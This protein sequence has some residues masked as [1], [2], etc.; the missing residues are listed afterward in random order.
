MSS[1]RAKETE[2][3]LLSKCEKGL[4]RIAEYEKAEENQEEAINTE[5]QYGMENHSLFYHCITVVIWNQD[6][7]LQSITR[8]FL[9]RFSLTS[10]AIGEVPPGEVVFNLEKF[11]RLFNHNTLHLKDCMTNSQDRA[12][13]TLLQ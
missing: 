4:L 13:K 1:I 8:E 9:E 6:F 2:K 5:H 12:Q 7:L 10:S 3:E 11:G